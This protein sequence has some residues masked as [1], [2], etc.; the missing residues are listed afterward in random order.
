MLLMMGGLLM[1]LAYTVLLLRGKVI[2]KRIVQLS[3]FFSM[4]GGGLIAISAML[5]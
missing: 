2:M 4:V 5:L 3:S 1:V